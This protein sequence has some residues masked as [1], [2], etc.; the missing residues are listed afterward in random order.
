MRPG[1]SPDGIGRLV[2][3]YDSLV[4]LDVTVFLRELSGWLVLSAG[5]VRPGR[6]WA[7]FER[8]D[9]VGEL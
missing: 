6:W 5:E 9:G 2:E 7:E 3:Q 8:L 1:D 4:E